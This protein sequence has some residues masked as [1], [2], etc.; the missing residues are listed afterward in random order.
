M[1]HGGDIYRNQV[2]LDFSVNTNPLGMSAGVK[3]ALTEAVEECIHYP[4]PWAE[5]LKRAVAGMLSVREEYLLFGNGAS[6]L[7]LA[8]VHGLR[9][10]R[11]VIPVPSFYGY[12]HAAAAGW[13]EIC[14]YPLKQ[15]NHF[16]VEEGLFSCLDE[17]TDLLFLANPNNPVGNLIPSYLLE[18]LLCH[19]KERGICVVLDECFIEFCRE[20]PSMISRIEEYDNLILIRAFTKTFAIP[21]V[22]LGYL[23]CS[24]RKLLSAI[25]R[26]LPE[27]NLSVFAQRAGAAC[28]REY[29][30]LDKMRETMQTEREFLIRG[31]KEAGFSVF[32]PE[33]N[34]VLVY[35]QLPLGKRLY[36]KGILIRDCSNFR[37]LSEGYFRIAVKTREENL[38]LLQAMGELI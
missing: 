16:A 12:E 28:V 38:K 7:F 22:R 23:V 36:E 17:K 1:I 20:V 19:C 11:T 18:R 10:K 14:Y 5:Q 21:G 13:G 25:V 4:D 24:N 9:P 35:T 37:G 30:M 3:K 26:Q 27:W 2:E 32:P 6:E 33:A 15:E 31:L 34:F 29:A 8:V